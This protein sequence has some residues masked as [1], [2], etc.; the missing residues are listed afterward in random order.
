MDKAKE[1]YINVLDAIRD[2]FEK[3][4]DL[5]VAQLTKELGMN[6]NT[7]KDVVK[8]DNNGRVPN[9]Q[10]VFAVAY[11]LN[12]DVQKI[13]Y[14]IAKIVSTGLGTHSENDFQKF[15]E[16]MKIMLSKG[17][18]SMTEQMKEKMEELFNKS[19]QLGENE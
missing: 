15:E 12:I 6:Y 13:M 17:F 7:L 19:K 5:T 14:P 10:T 3:R 8:G 16:S 4:D 11:Y 18:E 1:V 9:S 2:E